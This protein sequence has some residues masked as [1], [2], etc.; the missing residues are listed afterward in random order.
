MSYLAHSF[1]VPTAGTPT[2]RGLS[3]IVRK[4]RGAGQTF[5]NK[6]LLVRELLE[7]FESTFLTARASLLFVHV[8]YFF[9]PNLF[10]YGR[11]FL[12]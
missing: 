7:G 2:M 5:D 4:G 3:F 12:V 8:K 1:F 11:D 6:S 10:I 9:R